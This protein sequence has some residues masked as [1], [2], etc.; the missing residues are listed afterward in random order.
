[1]KI[2]DH[3]LIAITRHD[4]AEPAQDGDQRILFFE[5]VKNREIRLT[6]GKAGDY[7]NPWERFA[8]RRSAV[9]SR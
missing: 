1:M 7:T 6:H 8:R 2:P 4:A 3:I 9:R 5:T